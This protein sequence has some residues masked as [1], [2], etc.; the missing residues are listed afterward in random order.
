[1]S[2][3]KSM[4]SSLINLNCKTHGVREY[5]LNGNFGVDTFVA[6]LEKWQTVIKQKSDFI[7]L[8]FGNNHV[9]SLFSI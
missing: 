7:S 8:N 4:C 6:I 3:V 5:I 2:L 9:E 1:M